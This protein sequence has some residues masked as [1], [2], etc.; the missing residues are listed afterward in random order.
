MK[1]CY[2]VIDSFIQKE[3]DSLVSSSYYISFQEKCMLGV[4]MEKVFLW[5]GQSLC[6][7]GMLLKC[8]QIQDT[9]TIQGSL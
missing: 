7:C 5:A 1:R 3:K 4:L 8:H 6:T 2:L 9:L